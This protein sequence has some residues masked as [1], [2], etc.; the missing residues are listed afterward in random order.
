MREF[1]K[2]YEK[3]TILRIF[4][5][6]YLFQVHFILK[7]SEEYIVCLYATMYIFRFESFNDFQFY[8]EKKMII[9]K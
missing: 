6:I 2:F 3:F 9:D 4:M 5:N 1:N 7:V 8:F